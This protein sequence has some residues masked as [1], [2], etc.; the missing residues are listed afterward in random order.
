MPYKEKKYYPN[1]E[2]NSFFH[3]YNR[4]IDG[5]KIFFQ[6]R[7]Y[8]YFLRKFDQYLSDYLDIYAYCL[9][10][11]HFHLLVKLKTLK[12]IFKAAKEDFKKGLPKPL[13]HLRDRTDLGDRFGLNQLAGKIVS[14]RFN[15]F[16]LF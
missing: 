10:G 6:E 2:P 3:I 9:L 13:A 15:D 11:N 14:K 1:F 5:C 16:L 4:G 12:E 8:V 7:N